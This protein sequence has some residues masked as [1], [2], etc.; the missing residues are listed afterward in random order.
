MALTASGPIAQSHKVFWISP[1]CIQP[2]F[3]PIMPFLNE[4]IQL[5]SEISK[6]VQLKS[7]GGE[8]A[9]GND[10]I[11]QCCCFIPSVFSLTVSLVSEWKMGM[12]KL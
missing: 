8:R 9:R 5:M 4:T 2:M 3:K 10:R 1:V 12:R 7:A 6:A 11:K